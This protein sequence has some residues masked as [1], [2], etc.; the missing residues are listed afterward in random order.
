ML[1]TP[2]ITNSSNKFITKI[3]NL[4][5]QNRKIDLKKSDVV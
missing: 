4:R 2:N 5:G 3:V 1:Y